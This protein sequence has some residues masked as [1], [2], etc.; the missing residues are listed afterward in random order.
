MICLTLNRHRVVLL[1]WRPININ[2]KIK[3][4]RSLKHKKMNRIDELKCKIQAVSC[5]VLIEKCPIPSSFKQSTK[6]GEKNGKKFEC[7]EAL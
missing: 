7:E 3:A 4:K 1:Q 6:R 5:I 2:T